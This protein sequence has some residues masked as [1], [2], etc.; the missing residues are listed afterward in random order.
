M[1]D[2]TPQTHI[3]I[4]LLSVPLVIAFATLCHWP[5]HAATQAPGEIPGGTPAFANAADEGPDNP[6]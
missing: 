5:V 1:M 4:K 6:Q 3:S 2:P